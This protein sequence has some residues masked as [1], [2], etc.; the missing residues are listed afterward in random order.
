[1][2]FTLTIESDNDAVTDPQTGNLEVARIL[3]DAAQR[4]EDGAISNVC[5]DTNGNVVGHWRYDS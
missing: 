2:K 3:R 4:I 5:R 1:M